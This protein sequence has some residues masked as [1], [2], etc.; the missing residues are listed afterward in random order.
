MPDVP[1]Q[2]SAARKTKQSAVP[3]CRVCSR[4]RIRCDGAQ[5]ACEKCISRG[6]HCPGYGKTL[7]WICGPAS[8]G[9]NRLHF[10]TT[11]APHHSRRAADTP[12]VLQ[13]VT[14]SY[15]SHVVP[16]EHKQLPSLLSPVP[17][18]GTESLLLQHFADVVSVQLAWFEGESNPWRSIILPMALE[19]PGPSTSL[20]SL[21]SAILGVSAS[22]VASRLAEGDPQRDLY[23]RIMDSLRTNTFRLLS[24]DLRVLRSALQL[25]TPPPQLLIQQVI[26]SVLLLSYLE[27]HWPSNGM[28]HFHLRTAQSISNMLQFTATGDATNVFLSEELFAASTWPLLTNC[29]T[30]EISTIQ[31]LYSKSHIGQDIK[32][33]S[34]FIAFVII[35]RRVIQARIGIG[36]RGLE[37]GKQHAVL[38]TTL[39]QALIN[40]EQAYET[41]LRESTK[42]AS[43]NDHDLKLIITAYYHAT[44]IYCHQALSAPVPTLNEGL[45]ACPDQTTLLRLR[46]HLLDSLLSLNNPNALAQSQPWPLFILATVSAHDPVT[47]L[48]FEKRMNSI[49]TLYCEIDR[50]QMLKFLR[51]FW[52]QVACHNWIE[53]AQLWKKDHQRFLIL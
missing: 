31:E 42:T 49:M 35:I 26:A 28:W 41:A 50:P 14:P 30:N 16:Y 29:P 8:K 18:L 27:V 7:R 34:P 2:S 36:I 46:I 9:P 38:C 17:I 19:S 24:K 23:L 40:L 25:G 4:R 20:C 1:N 48:W 10:R 21:L 6:L 43:V 32:G 53:Y 47:H 39:Q 15:L 52:A 13:P 33:H 22:N 51:S 44:Q 37:P 3:G 45:C 5:P 11:P 12:I